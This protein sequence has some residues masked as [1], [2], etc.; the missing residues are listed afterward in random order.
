[1]LTL[2]YSAAELKMS[3]SVKN[4]AA[5]SSANCESVYIYCLVF[6]DTL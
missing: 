1:M 5:V 4:I 3:S 2:C 6:D